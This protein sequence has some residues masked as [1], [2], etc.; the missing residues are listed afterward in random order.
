MSDDTKFRSPSEEIERLTQE[1]AEIKSAMREIAGRLSQIERHARRSLGTPRSGKSPQSRPSQERP[2]DSGAP[3]VSREEALKVFEDLTGIWRDR[4]G[5]EVET[6]LAQLGA[7]D[8]KLMAHEL[9][10]SFENKPSRRGLQDGI[11]G[12]IKE[13]V[14]LSRNTNVTAPRSAEAPTSTPE[15]KD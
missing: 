6:R 13:S 12:R 2:A 7:P 1:I 14:M 9:G 3:T 10:L 5:V 15:R 11:I 4:G 8:L